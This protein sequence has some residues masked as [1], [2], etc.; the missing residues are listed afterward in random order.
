MIAMLVMAYAYA[1]GVQ[2]NTFA[3]EHAGAFFSLSF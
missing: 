3:L 1:I 2:G